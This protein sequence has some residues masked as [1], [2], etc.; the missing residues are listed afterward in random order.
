MLFVPTVFR[1]STH[2]G[3]EDFLLGLGHIMM[4]LKLYKPFHYKEV[5]FAKKARRVCYRYMSAIEHAKIV[6][7]G[8]RSNHNNDIFQKRGRPKIT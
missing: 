5:N 6:N 8:K 1:C 4:E 2:V 7:R 3:I